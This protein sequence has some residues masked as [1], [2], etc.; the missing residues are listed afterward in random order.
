MTQNKAKIKNSK[1]ASKALSS[2]LSWLKVRQLHVYLTIL[3]YTLCSII[4][5]S[6]LDRS[7]QL[8]EG[9]L[10]RENKSKKRDK[11]LSLDVSPRKIKFKNLWSTL[12]QVNS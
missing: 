6:R 11:I 4:S 9:C 8:A 7:A 2:R 1:I 5:N 10:I 12:R 3:D